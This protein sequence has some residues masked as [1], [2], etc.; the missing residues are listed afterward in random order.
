MC[1]WFKKI[2]VAKGKG[3]A[4]HLVDNMLVWVCAFVRS[5]TLRLLPRGLFLRVLIL[6]VGVMVAITTRA[7]ASGPF[8]GVGDPYPVENSRI[9]AEQNVYYV[10]TDGSDLS[11]DGS[12]INPWATITQ[13][14]DSVPDGSTV[15]VRSGT[16]NGRVRLRGTFSEGVTVSA[17]VPYQARLRHDSTVVTCFYGQGITLEGFDIAHDGPGAGALVIQIQDLLGEP[18]GDSFVSR[19]TLRNN[20]LHDSYD[21]DLLK[22]NNGAGQITVEGNVFYNQT[23]HDEHIDVN[24][25]TDI[26]IQDNIFFNDFSGSGRINRD[27]TGSYIVIKGNCSA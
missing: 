10:A 8:W 3:P 23:G 14:L 9:L 13:A 11:G 12:D 20:V 6:L 19:I 1:R 27:D 26:V 7:T 5:S 21:N 4:H 18:G 2:E 15:L 16:Y 22:V 25:V 17:Q 24:S